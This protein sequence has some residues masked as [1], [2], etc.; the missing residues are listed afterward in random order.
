MAKYFIN[1]ET[2]KEIADAIKE[3]TKNQ[4]NMYPGDMPSKIRS[5]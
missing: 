2:L 4:A 3:K 5:I 1:S